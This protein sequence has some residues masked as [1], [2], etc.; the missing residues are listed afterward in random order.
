MDPRP[1]D[2]VRY[3]PGSGFEFRTVDGDFSLALGAWMQVRYTWNGL[4]GEDRHNLELAKTR[5]VL[6]GNLWGKD[7]R[8]AFEFG[9]AGRE[10]DRSPVR[11]DGLASDQDVLKNGPVLNAYVDFRQLRDLSVRVGQYKVPFSRQQVAAERELEAIERAITDTTFAFGRDI[12]VDLWSDD[13]GGLGLLRYHAGVYGGEGRNAWE[14]TIGAG[15]HG[16]LY[17]VR[18]E[19]LPLGLFNEYTEVDFARAGPRL[20]IGAAY[21]LLQSDATSPLARQYIAEPFDAGTAPAVVDFNA[22]NAT[23]DAMFMAAGFS[24]QA[25]FHLRKVDGVPGGLDGIGFLIAANYLLPTVAL[26]PGASLSLV[27]GDDGSPLPDANELV[28]FAQYFFAEHLL[29][30]QADYSRLWGEA[31]FSDGDDRVRVQLQA[32]L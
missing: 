10:L 24:A 30:L 13:L 17:N 16:F 20:S 6:A 27:R 12:G 14:R 23:A 3:V 2:A 18:L 15:D 22:H 1:G 31:G 28:V 19:V 4:A 8:Y 32:S 5:L 11:V 25:A 7:T 26:A 9:L 21:A 29:K